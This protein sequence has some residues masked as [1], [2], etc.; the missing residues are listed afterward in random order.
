MEAHDTVGTGGS[1][2]A[3]PFPVSSNRQKPELASRNASGSATE[4]PCYFGKRILDVALA[5]FG[6]LSTVPLSVFVAIAIKL[7]DGGP[8]LFTQQRIGRDGERFVAYKFRTLV[9]RDLPSLKGDPPDSTVTR[10]GQLLRRTAFDELPQLLNILKG[11]MSLVG[12]R[13]IPARELA[14]ETSITVES[15]PGFAKRMSVRPGL[16]GIA[17][18][19]ADRDVSYRAK[20]RYDK[21]YVENQSLGLDLYLIC[22]SFWISVS[23]RWPKVGHES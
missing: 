9:D 17:Q 3:I 20:F 22:K 2:R 6:L 11:D 4:S 1:K 19:E 18:T 10:V 5:A 8:V 23:G 12:P 15:V 16:T 14:E 13:A 21:L 7:E